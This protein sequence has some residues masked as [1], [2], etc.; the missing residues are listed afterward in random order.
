[1]IPL[2]TVRQEPP[3]GGTQTALK[4]QRGYPTPHP[5][6]WPRARRERIAGFE[7]GTGGSGSQRCAA[8]PGGRERCRAWHRGAERDSASNLG[9]F[10]SR[11]PLRVGRRSPWPSRARAVPPGE[12]AQ[13]ALSLGLFGLNSHRFLGLAE[14]TGLD[15]FDGAGPPDGTP[16]RARLAAGYPTPT[17]GGA[18]RSGRTGR[19]RPDS[20]PSL[21]TNFRPRF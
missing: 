7:G 2:A 12:G 4:P 14:S 8:L 15:L 13:G 11:L 9:A 10:S 5:G 17:P 3:P 19:G 18:S 1:M 20:L 16:T 6:G 21:P